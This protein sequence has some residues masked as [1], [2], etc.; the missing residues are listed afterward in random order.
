MK[1][2]VLGVLTVLVFELA[3]VFGV[4][5]WLEFNKPRNACEGGAICENFSQIKDTID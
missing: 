1:N 2:F 4:G 5:L 3:F